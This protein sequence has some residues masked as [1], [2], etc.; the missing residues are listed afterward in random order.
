MKRHTE[1]HSQAQRK[2]GA[3][4]EGL[5]GTD[6]VILQ[7]GL[8]EGT[9]EPFDEPSGSGIE[10]K[11]AELK[12]YTMKQLEGRLAYYKHKEACELNGRMRAM[13]RREIHNTQWAINWK[14]MN[15][16]REFARA[17]E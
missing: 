6:T 11:Q 4:K 15:T 8:A 3:D 5:P 2:A 1:F 16:N 13:Y 14:R 10:A 9:A 7:R 17:A 12:K